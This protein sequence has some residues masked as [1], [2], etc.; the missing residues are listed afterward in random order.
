[1]QPIGYL[2][3]QYPAYNHTYI[4]REVTLLRSFGW[5]V[6]TA[7]IRNDPRPV[8]HIMEEESRERNSTYYVV[9]QGLLRSILAHA[10]CAFHRPKSYIRGWRTATR[11]SG[12]SP[13]SFLSY[14]IYLT[15]ALIAGRYFSQSGVS[16]FHTHYASTVG[17]L[18]TEVFPIQMSMTIHGSGEF[19][20]GLAF[21]ME[22][23][24][25][26]SCFVSTISYY[27][28]AQILK[29]IDP[30]LWN[31]VEVLR[32]G[33]D[34]TIFQAPD[35]NLAGGKCKI[36]TV[37]KIIPAKGVPILIE[38]FR[39]LVNKGYDAQLTIV[40]DGP[41]LP[42]LRQ[43]TDMAG[44]SHQVVFT[45][46]LNQQALRT[47]Y[48]QSDIFALPSFAEAVPVVLMEAMALKLP[49]VATSVGGITELISHNID[50]LLVPPADAI[51]FSEA[52]ESLVNDR[53]RARQLGEAG[54]RKVRNVYDI[55]KNTAQFAGRLEHWHFGSGLRKFE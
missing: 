29:S 50:G 23:K 43:L 4:L 30:K 5:Q 41:S 8:E 32:L 36:I 25:A 17:L 39:L 26:A 13:K 47:L 46:A 34:L 33:V 48:S 42:D 16:H 14:A 27:G 24:V 18:L 31:K 15:E 40:G 45:G 52:L 28:K 1:M 22:E 49:C 51:T 6:I 55:H 9:S 37:S 20:A 53:Q 12:L 10:S 54:A 44:L 2:I 7:S 21:H 38:S 11:L 19:E 35:Q 3:S